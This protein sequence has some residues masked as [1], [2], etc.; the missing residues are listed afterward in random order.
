M[1]A[2]KNLSQIVT[3]ESAYKKD[4]RRVKNEDLSI[5][6]NGTIVFDE[7]EI[8]WVGESD[9]LPKKF[10]DIPS[11]NL[12]GKVLTPE[13][14][15]PH[16]HTLFGGN[17]SFEYTLRLNGADYEEIAKSGGGILNTTKATRESSFEELYKS[18]KEK[19]IKI[20]SYGIDT[21]ESKIL[22][23]CLLRK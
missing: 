18:T 2:Y 6:E 23:R 13:I 22:L 15:D 19:I 5:I 12:Q 16:T 10:L 9:K 11:E 17:R 8:I 20:N 21:I 1:K 3:L 14:V 7:D 4:G